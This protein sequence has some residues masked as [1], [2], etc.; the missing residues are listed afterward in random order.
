MTL[1]G[2]MKGKEVLEQAIA[3][4][5]LTLKAL[6]LTHAHIDHAGATGTLARTHG[7]PSGLT[8]DEL[9]PLRWTPRVSPRATGRRWQ[10]AGA[11]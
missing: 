4:R 10:W 3:S 9:N 2:M 11:R 8:P 6:W 7:V 1:Y 5:G